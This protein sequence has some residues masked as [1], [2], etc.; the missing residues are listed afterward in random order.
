M[1][2]EFNDSELLTVIAC[3]A[4]VGVNT[5][6]AGVGVPLLASILAKST[7]SPNLTIVV[8]G[9]SI[10]PE[11]IPGRLPISTNEMRISYRA[12]Q[13]MGNTDIFL[14]TQRGYL[15]FGFIGGAQID[16]F[17]NVNTTAIGS[18][19]KPK[20]RLPGSG[21]ANDIISLCR[22][23]VLVTKHEKRR[24]VPKVDFITSPGYLDGGNTRRKAGLLFGHITQVI[25]DLAI[26]DFDPETKAMKLKGLYPHTTIEQVLDLTGFDLI[27][28][29]EIEMIKPPTFEEIENL[30]R[31]ENVR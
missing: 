20:V 31:I 4:M 1:Q 18:Y 6:F 11:V 12:Q 30:R 5:I 2:K 21:G 19:D 24:F 10:G 7:H 17:G 16:R 22:K 29:D 13:L 23:I 26:M 3:R 28:P 25:T 8:E 9:G 27:V 15:E 14:L